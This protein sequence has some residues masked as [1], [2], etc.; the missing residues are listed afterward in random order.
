MSITASLMAARRVL[1]TPRGRQAMLWSCPPKGGSCGMLCRAGRRVVGGALTAGVLPT[2]CLV[3]GR[4]GV[5]RVVDAVCSG[6]EDAVRARVEQ[7]AAMVPVPGPR[8]LS[9]WS[10]PADSSLNRA[11]NGFFPR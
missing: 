10:S 1:C 9:G 7:A 8:A 11:F 4:A 3:G 5:E 6:D 2:V